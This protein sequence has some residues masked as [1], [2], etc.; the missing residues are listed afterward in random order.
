MGG[1]PAVG[2]KNGFNEMNG[3]HVRRWLNPHSD[4]SAG[5]SSAQAVAIQPDGKVIAA[6]SAGNPNSVFALARYKLNGSLDS[7]FGSGGQLT[8]SLGL[9]LNGGAKGVAIQGDG[10]IVVAGFA[11]AP[12]TQEFALVRYNPDGSLDT[13]FGT[14]GTVRHGDP[15][16]LPAPRRDHPPERQELSAQESTADG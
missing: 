4:F 10:K 15:G 7:S 2:P 13:N 1:Q 14:G 9:N 11:A 12:G 5:A 16:S 8:T 3:G 6:G